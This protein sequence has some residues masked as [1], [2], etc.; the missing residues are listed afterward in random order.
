MGYRITCDCCGHE[1]FKKEGDWICKKCGLNHARKILEP[2]IDEECH[3][4]Q[5]RKIYERKSQI[6][7]EISKLKGD[8]DILDREYMQL[9]TEE[10]H[11][12]KLDVIIYEQKLLGKNKG[13]NNAAR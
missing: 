9:E 11:L 3:I 6:L 7:L 13:D 2:T 4:N 5:K 10:R 12:C 8:I 1:W